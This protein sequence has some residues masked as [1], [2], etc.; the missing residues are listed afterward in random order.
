M[1]IKKV[2]RAFSHESSIHNFTEE[3]TW[4]A[5]YQII[6]RLFWNNIFSKKQ[7]RRREV[8]ERRDNFPKPQTKV[9]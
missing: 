1:S 5:I 7:A 4:K 3:L 9:V 2:T 6:K 8:E